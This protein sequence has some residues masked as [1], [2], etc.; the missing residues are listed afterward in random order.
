MVDIG[1][2]NDIRYFISLLPKQRQSLFFSATISVK[3]KEILQNFV[4]NPVTVSVKQ[5][6]TAENINQ[7]IVKV[8]PGY[9][10]IDTLHDLLA[11]DGFNKVLI[12]GRTKWGIQNLTDE[13]IKRGFKAG[14]IHGIKR[15]DQR[16]R[17]LDQFKNT[18]Y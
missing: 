13:L 18:E 6:E 17:T 9:K 15:Q 14:A 3:V 11:Q 2:I 10:K 5:Q 16:Q 1:F 8:V 4:H 12:F 7:D